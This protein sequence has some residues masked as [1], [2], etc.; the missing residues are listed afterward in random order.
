MVCPPFLD[1]IQEVVRLMGKLLAFRG[2]F[3][4]WGTGDVATCTSPL[5]LTVGSVA[6]PFGLHV[7]FQNE[8]LWKPKASAT[9]TN[10][11]PVC[12]IARLPR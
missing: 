9:N 1:E 4:A 8:R 12:V 10:I 3:A 11:C 7:S 2:G 5:Q 6:E